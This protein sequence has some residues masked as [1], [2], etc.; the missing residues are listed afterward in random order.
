MSFMLQARRPAHVGAG[1]VRSTSPS[2]KLMLAAQ[3][4]NKLGDVGTCHMVL[5]PPFWKIWGNR[6][7]IFAATRLTTCC[8]P[9]RSASESDELGS[10]IDMENL[11]FVIRCWVSRA[12]P[13][14]TKRAM[15]ARTTFHSLWLHVP[16]PRVTVAMLKLQTMWSTCLQDCLVLEH[17]DLVHRYQQ[18]TL[19]QQRE[20]CH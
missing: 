6:Y 12:A 5:C 17:V 10:P 18:Y 7:V 19:Y 14:I 9:L 8:I 2:W 20:M 4:T 13:I 16:V 3:L 11:I 1:N 15:H